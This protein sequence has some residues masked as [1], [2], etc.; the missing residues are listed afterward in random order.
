MTSHPDPLGTT[1]SVSHTRNPAFALRPENA[2]AVA[3][4]CARLEELPLAMELAAAR[5]KLLPPQALLSRL[6]NRLKLLIGGPRD[7]SE[8]QRTL[9]S[10]IEWS[11]GLLEAGEKILLGR[12]AVFSGGS[13][14]EAIEAVCDAQGDLPVDVLDGA[15]SLLDNSLLR[16]EVVAGDEPRFVMLE[17]IHEFALEKL[18]ESSDAEAIKRAHAEYL[19][20]LK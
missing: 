17:T 10:A 1:Y 2:Q 14:L 5:I 3:E 9:R 7:F 12:L 20:A 4:I 6:G 19:L 16:Q 15:S 18:E 8:R 11:Y 13:I